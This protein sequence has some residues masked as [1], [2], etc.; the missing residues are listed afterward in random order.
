[1]ITPP[2]APRQNKISINRRCCMT[3][4]NLCSSWVKSKAAFLFIVMMLPRVYVGNER[5]MSGNRMSPSNPRVA[6][7]AL[8][9]KSFLW[10]ADHIPFCQ[11]HVAGGTL[12]DGA[13]IEFD[14]RT[15]LFMKW[16]H[17]PA[18]RHRH[19]MAKTRVRISVR[20]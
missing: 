2:S 4:S 6:A 8:E 10:D 12:A 7:G 20:P 17:G 1:M 19:G 16:G 15:N 14:S 13:K 9:C 3:D 5:S 18:G 11:R